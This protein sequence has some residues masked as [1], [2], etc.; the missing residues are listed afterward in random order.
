MVNKL[1]L[2]E[3][4]EFHGALPKPKV[5]EYMSK[6]DFFVLPSLFETFGCVLIEAMSCGKPVLATNIGGPG[7]IITQQTGILVEPAN[8]EALKDGIDFM[9]DNYFNYSADDIVNYVKNHF[10]FEAIGLKL[11]QLYNDIIAKK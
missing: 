7:E 2:S 10:S 8:S 11:N 1:D 5:A 4:V 9:L 3:F 6:C